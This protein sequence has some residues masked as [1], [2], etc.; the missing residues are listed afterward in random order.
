MEATRNVSLQTLN[1]LKS[2][3]SGATIEDMYFN[4]IPLLRKKPATLV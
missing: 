2:C 4:L 3:F 1:Q